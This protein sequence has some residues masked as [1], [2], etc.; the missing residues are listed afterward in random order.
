[1]SHALKQQQLEK[2]YTTV[3]TCKITVGELLKD[4]NIVLQY[5]VIIM[6][7]L[8]LDPCTSKCNYSIP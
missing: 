3:P 7:M 1:M 5:C 8:L 4:C 6:C 2:D